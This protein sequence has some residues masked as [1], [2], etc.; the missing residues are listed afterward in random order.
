MAETLETKGT[1]LHGAKIEEYSILADGETAALVSR[2]GSIDWL[3]WPNFASGACFA[4]LL[5]T[6][7]HGFWKI[8]PRVEV[9]A[10]TR[11][12]RPGTMILET[13]FATSGGKAV[14]TDC[15]PP[16]ARSIVRTVKCLSG[17]IDMKS[18][19]SI[20]FDY[21]RTIPWVTCERATEEWG[22]GSTDTLHA[23]A[24]SEA[25]VFRSGSK[26]KALPNHG[27]NMSTVSDFS[28]SEGQTAWF[29]LQ[30]GV[31]FADRPAPLDVGAEL[32]RTESFWKDWIGK[33]RYKGKYADVVERSLLTLKALT[34]VES[35]GIV[36]AATASL[37]E[38]IGGSRN[39]DYRYC[40][41]RDA[42]FTLLVLLHAGFEQEAVDWRMWLLRAVAGSP[43]QVQTIYG[44]RGERQLLEWK[45]AWLPGYEHSQPVNI[46][47]AAVEQF[48]LDVFGELASALYR[49]PD[50]ADDLRISAA[51]MQA[52]LANHVCDVWR[53]PDDGIWET[54]GGR[55]HFTYSKV[56]AWLALERTVRLSDEGRDGYFAPQD[57]A[58]WRTV[59]DAIHAD[60]CEHGFNK[61]INA[62]TQAYGSTDLDASCLRI[63]MVGFLP[64]DD[65]RIVGTVEAI[66]KQL[67]R[68]GFVL[69]YKTEGGGDGLPPGEGA[70]LACSFWLV[71][72]WALMGRAAEASALFERLVG[73]A[74]DVGLL[75]EEWDPTAKRMLGNFPQ[76]LSHIALCHAAFTLAGEWKPSVGNR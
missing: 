68:D 17:R 22:E 5:G 67:M 31:V 4:A 11:Q 33:S 8:A 76:A 54:R 69:R 43:E 36:A 32:A 13:I 70:F 64:F 10:N 7:E 73:L 1:A 15:M 23:V 71:V 66:E 57:V 39:W 12:Y 30:H 63:P 2:E 18:D 6:V 20:R 29:T 65:P 42:S 51:A 49:M 38:K 74:N 24:G 53:E 37:P 58:R 25:I 26:D 44:I 46:G 60:V 3:C 35:G 14:L 50:A 21:G 40:W 55:Q 59:R 27:E 45:A 28:L 47:N 41:L 75:S 52:N 9:I 56:S 16:G 34:Y 19:L 62:F 72:C 48:Q 61:E